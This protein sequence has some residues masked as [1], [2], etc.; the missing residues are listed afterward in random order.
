[1]QL[2]LCEKPSQAR[3]IARVLGIRQKRDGCLQGQEATVTWCFGHLLEMVPPDG[4][5]PAYKRW[6]LETLPIVPEQWKLAVKKEARQQ[7]TIIQQLLKAAAQ[8]VIATDADRE[9]ETIAREVLQRC[10]WRGPV[11]RLWLSA[12]DDASIRKALSNRLPG[13]KTEALYAAGLGRARADWLVGMNLTRAYTVIGR[14]TGH[15]RVLSVGRVQTPTLNL[16]VQRDAAIERFKPSPY[17][18]IQALFEVKTGQFNAKWC[19]PKALTDSEGRCTDQTVA[20]GVVQKIAGRD[21]TIIRAETTR[22]REAAP[23]PFD[24]STLQQ[25]ASKRW[26]LGAQD[27]LNTAQALYETHKALTYPRTDCPYLPESQRSEAPQVLSALKQSDAAYSPLV[28]GAEPQARSRAWNDKKITAHHAII[29]TATPTDVSKMSETEQRLYDLVC[30]RY[31]AQFYP[32][33]EYGK[34]VIEARVGGERFLTAG[35][36][37]RIEGW[38]RVVTQRKTDPK[39]REAQTLPPVT[40]GDAAHVA[41]ATLETKQTQPPPR[42]TEGTLIAAMKSIGKHVSDPQLKRVL[43]DTAGLGTEATRAG[44]IEANRAK[45]NDTQRLARDPVRRRPRPVHPAHSVNPVR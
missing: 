6:R 14:Q 5:D 32:P 13:A 29:P 45:R 33:Y 2:Y 35:N 10:R 7:Y 44:I 21:G 28:D 43:R 34:T 17:Y 40:V 39:E 26:G 3:D 12:L 27:V 19:P 23:L 16:V 37:P 24:L 31:L 30:R 15:D 25:D 8:V 18:D 11:S 4:Y 42:Y 36:V 41:D 22:E 9:G 1:M 20:Q 38:R